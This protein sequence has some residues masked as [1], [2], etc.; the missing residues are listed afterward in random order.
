MANY[1]GSGSPLYNSLGTA[2][3]SAA[4]DSYVRDMSEVRDALQSDEYKITEAK[5][6]E[7]M[8][9][10]RDGDR[11]REVQDVIARF[12]PEIVEDK[13]RSKH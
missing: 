1:N 8:N 13:D 7:M 9:A 3:A 6:E 4:S 11:S 5:K 12:A 2:S 10:Y